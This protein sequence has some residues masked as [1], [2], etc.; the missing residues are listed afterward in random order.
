MCACVCGRLDQG[1]PA[2][3]LQAPPPGMD[4]SE[5]NAGMENSCCGIVSVLDGWFVVS[6]ET[7]LSPDPHQIQ[8]R[9]GRPSALISVCPRPAHVTIETVHLT[10]GR[11]MEGLSDDIIIK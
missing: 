10:A 8:I 6:V 3:R 5:I 9:S 2:P 1:D 7:I 11:V 4:E